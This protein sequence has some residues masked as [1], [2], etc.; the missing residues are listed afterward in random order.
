MS[1]ANTNS[2]GDLEQYISCYYHTVACV[3]YQKSKTSAAPNNYETPFTKEIM[4]FFIAVFFYNA[5]DIVISLI[6]GIPGN[7]SVAVH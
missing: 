3:R 7:F 4:I 1:G 6:T 2:L 5:F